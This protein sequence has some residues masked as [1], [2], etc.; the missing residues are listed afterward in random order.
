MLRVCLSTRGDLGVGSGIKLARNRPWGR[1]ADHRDSFVQP[2][3]VSTTGAAQAA[4]QSCR[5][6]SQAGGWFGGNREGN[7]GFCPS[8]ARAK[9]AQPQG[10]IP[11]VP[12]RPAASPP[13]LPHAKN[14]AAAKIVFVWRT[15]PHQP[16]LCQIFFP[17]PTTH[18]PLRQR[19]N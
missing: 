3:A 15:L 7:G 4:L 9:I 17:K 14:R 8:G 5:S 19:P 10:F 18:A 13:G 11:P 1:I 16:G 12:G 2:A 6:L